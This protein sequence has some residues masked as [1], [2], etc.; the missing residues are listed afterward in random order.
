MLVVTAVMFAVHVSRF[1]LCLKYEEAHG[2]YM[3]TAHAL[4]HALLIVILF[5]GKFR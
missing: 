2:T 3:N 1:Q 4:M 5:S